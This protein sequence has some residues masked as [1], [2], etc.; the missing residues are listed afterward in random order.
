MRETVYRAVA[1]GRAFRQW[2]EAML[3]R[4]PRRPTWQRETGRDS[5]RATPYEVIGRPSGV[6]AEIDALR[7][8]IQTSNHSPRRRDLWPVDP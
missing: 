1:L 4:M 2:P 6:I 8:L 7:A 5:Q 3:Y